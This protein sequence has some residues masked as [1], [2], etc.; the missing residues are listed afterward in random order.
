MP[1]LAIAV[2]S[3]LTPPRLSLLKEGN[4][5]Q[6]KDGWYNMNKNEI[7]CSATC[8]IWVLEGWRRR[9]VVEAGWL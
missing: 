6:G 3:K 1:F 8:T 2:I 4:N 7:T 9:L 5:V